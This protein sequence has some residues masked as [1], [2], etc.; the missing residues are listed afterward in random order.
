[1]PEERLYVKIVMPRQGKEKKKTGGGGKVEPFTPVTTKARQ[2]LVDG[3]A[4]AEQLLARV[5]LQNRLVP[6]KASLIPKALAKS[7]WQNALF[8]QSSCPVIRGRQAR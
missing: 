4:A 5:S 3:L 1:M 7:H 2:R 6:L 8:D